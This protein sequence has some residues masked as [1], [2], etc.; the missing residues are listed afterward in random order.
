MVSPL[1]QTLLEIEKCF[2]NHCVVYCC[3]LN[4]ILWFPQDLQHYLFNRVPGYLNKSVLLKCCGE[5]YSPDSELCGHVCDGTPTNTGRILHC[6]A[7]SES[8]P[9][10][11]HPMLL[12]PLDLWVLCMF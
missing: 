5:A 4:Q 1:S 8:V 3:L 10:F 9:L 7:L 11:T 2:L 12:N 6:V